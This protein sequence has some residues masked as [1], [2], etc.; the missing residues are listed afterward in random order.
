MHLPELF[1]TNTTTLAPPTT[2]TTKDT[3]HTHNILWRAAESAR[4][5]RDLCGHARAIVVCIPT[6]TTRHGQTTNLDSA[7]SG[8]RTAATRLVRARARHTRQHDK[9]AM[10]CRQRSSNDRRLHG[11][12]QMRAYDEGAKLHRRYLTNH[13]CVRTSGP[14]PRHFTISTTGFSYVTVS[15]HCKGQR[16]PGHG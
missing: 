10:P 3:H 1:T 6:T 16:S 14:L 4:S 7:R 5:Q 8:A 9:G 2:T 11:S 15:Q 12:F 13:R